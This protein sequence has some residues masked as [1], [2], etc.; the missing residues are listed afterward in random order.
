MIRAGW[1]YRQQIRTAVAIEVIGWATIIA[2]IWIDSHF[3]GLFGIFLVTLGWLKI[4]YA[5]GVRDGIAALTKSDVRDLDF[6]T[7]EPQ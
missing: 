1:N 7:K 6:T 5:Q 3:A 4:R 2:T